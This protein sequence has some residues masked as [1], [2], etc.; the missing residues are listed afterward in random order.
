MRILAIAAAAL[1]VVSLTACDTVGNL[2]PPPSP[3]SIA[4]K[5]TLDEKVAITVETGATAAAE[6]A[7]L[8][9]KAGVIKGTTNLERLRSA[10]AELRRAVAATRA[11]YNAGNATSYT[12]AA[13]QATAAIAAIT[14]LAK[15]N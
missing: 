15:G 5:T 3:S 6:L 12:D 8:A 1:A 7:T 2:T 4:D 10:N 11:A 14:A 9:V 13:N